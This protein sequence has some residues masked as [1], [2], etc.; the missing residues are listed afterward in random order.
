[1]ST[2][3]APGVYTEERSTGPRAIAGVST[4]TAAFIGVAERGPV[5]RPILITGFAEFVRRF[6]GPIGVVPGVRE[7][8]LYFAVRHFFEL[9]GTRC[10]VVRVAHYT[11]I[12]SAATLEA[13]PAALLLAG[14][15]LDPT[16]VLTNV[17][18]ALRIA[19]SSPGKWGDAINVSVTPSTQFQLQLAQAIVAGANH[20]SI[21]LP[22]NDDV[23]LGTVLQLVHE[24]TGVVAGVD[25]T[26]KT[27]DFTDKL[28]E[29]SAFSA[30]TIASGTGTVVFKP[31]FS[32]IT[33]TNLAAAVNLGATNPPAAGSVVLADVTDI[34]PGDAL[35]FTVA[36]AF[37]RVLAIEDALI[38]TTPVMRAIVAPAATP[39]TLPN[40][41]VA[42]TRVYSRGFDI[43][44]RIGTDV[45][46]THRNLSLVAAHPSDYVN[47]R[48]G[49][50]SAASLY[51]VATEQLGSTAEV[52]NTP[53]GFTA[54]S[55]LGNDGLANLSV[56]DFE[57][58][59]LAKNGL[60][61][62]DPIED[63]S[64]LVIGYS[65][66]TTSALPDPTAHQR[67]LAGLAIGWVEKRKDMFYIVDPP[68]TG[69][70]AVAGVRTFAAALSS[71]YAG[72]YFPWLA[73][74]DPDTGDR[75]IV[76]PS[77]AVGGIFARSDGRRGVHKAPAGL[78]VGLVD[79]ATGTAYDVTRGENDVLY[80]EKINAI[81][82]MTDGIVVWGSRT[83]SADP[84]WLQTNVRRLFI[85]LERSIELGTQW[86]VF[87]P[88]DRSLWKTIERSIKS[89]LFLE[90]IDKKLVGATQDEAFF[91]RCNEET[92]PPEVVDS[93][94]VVTEIG[95]APSRPAEFVVFRIRQYAGKET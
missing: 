72:I 47:V 84:L 53:V 14:Q 81:R 85:Y 82:N 26:A 61:A 90:W 52:F 70:N 35:H 5:G 34:A 55:T 10:Y 41:P 56:S 46:E 37:V 31:D 24:I 48:L 95:V 23:V 3:L 25:A 78:D 20:T 75:I 71:S 9:G 12:N 19:A 59:D 15:A 62:L 18:G 1:M 65:R 42:P 36:Q 45:V 27:V 63:A 54:M 74:A 43:R 89:F 8:Y 51:I 88:N 57:G 28:L 40:L 87:E 58:S 38:G 94:M 68:R 92:N 86:V 44:V 13:T 79:I 76:P 6:G 80:P 60:H 50:D 17:P 93:G 16:N 2:Y 39:I 29:G 22:A 21:L 66:I 91:V 11:N 67:N 73:V 69:S 32:R 30:A 83:L 4:S 64:I 49:D 7:H 77:G 33:T